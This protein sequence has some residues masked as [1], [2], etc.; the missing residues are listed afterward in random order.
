MGVGKLYKSKHRRFLSF[1][2]LSGFVYYGLFIYLLTIQLEPLLILGLYLFRL[3][4]Q[5]VI[6]NKV[7]TKLRCADLIWWLPIFDFVYYLYLNIFGLIGTFTK[8][9]QWK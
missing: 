2:A 7:F 9:K 3:I 5:V 8:T 6:Y 4:L 1:D